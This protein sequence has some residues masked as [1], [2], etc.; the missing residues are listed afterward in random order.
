VTARHGRTA[1]ILVAGLAL[2]AL[3]AWRA[4]ASAVHYAS[5]PSH[6]PCPAITPGDHTVS[7]PTPEGPRP[8]LLHASRA[9]YMPRPLVI[10]LHGADPATYSR[11]ASRENFLVAYP[12]GSGVT[13]A[14]MLT[15]LEASLCI[16]K[17]R[18]Y[19][20]GGATAARLACELSPRLAGVAVIGDSRTLRACRPAR[21][22]PV[23]EIHGAT[24]LRDR[25]TV[26]RWLAHWRH[27]DRCRGL[28]T[29]LVPGRGVTEIAWRHCAAQTRV[30]DVQVG[31]AAR[32]WPGAPRTVQS[33]AAWRVWQLFRTLPQ[34]APVP[35]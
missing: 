17:S 2:L 28:A 6:E 18:V 1:V 3:V 24:T 15:R 27:I 5:D 30:Q 8:V 31:R 32:A 33:A 16:N 19:V 25:A 20:A 34:R 10:A 23:L 4:G 12:S 14:E 22:L 9:A 29:R 26:D 21:P 11:M 13:G 7:V 35:S